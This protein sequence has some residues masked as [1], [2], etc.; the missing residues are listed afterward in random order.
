MKK[1]DEDQ[2]FEIFTNEC[3][4]FTRVTTDT[5][6]QGWELPITRHAANRSLVTRCTM[7]VLKAIPNA[8]KYLEFSIEGLDYYLGR[9]LCS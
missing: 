9:T 5:G 2:D 3:V 6:A 8:G 7:H 1:S 4:F